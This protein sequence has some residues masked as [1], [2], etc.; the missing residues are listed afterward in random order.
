MSTSMPERPAT[1]KPPDRRAWLKA[2]ANFCALA[3]MADEKTAAR[4]LR[5]LAEDAARAASEGAA[6]ER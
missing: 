1:T 3:A 5:V 4:A 2:A 6:N